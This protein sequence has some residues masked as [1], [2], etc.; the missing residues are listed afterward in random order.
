MENEVIERIRKEYKDITEAINSNFRE[1]GMLESNAVVRRYNYLKNLRDKYE[2]SPDFKTNKS[3]LDHCIEEYGYGKPR[4][5]NEIWLYMFEC[6][7]ERF[8]QLFR[9]RLLEQDKSKI[10]V[11]YYDI[12]NRA[13]HAIVPK[14]NQEEYEST[15]NVVYGKETIYD[16]M[17]R[18]YNLRREFFV[19]CVGEGQEKAVEMVL[20]KYPKNIK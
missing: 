8:E 2:Y 17:D 5:T 6:S 16:C 7:I 1:L 14:E 11:V 20:S 15:H 19:S 9:V 3:I 13:K 4:Q 18:Y 12:E 10:V